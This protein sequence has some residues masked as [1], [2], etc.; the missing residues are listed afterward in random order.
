MSKPDWS[1]ISKLQRA[2]RIAAGLC[3][4]CARNP[5]T[6][7]S[8]LCDECANKQHVRQRKK[9][10]IDPSLPKIIP[11]LDHHKANAKCPV[12][13]CIV[14]VWPKKRKL[15]KHGHKIDKPPCPGSG[16]VPSVQPA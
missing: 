12:C 5:G 4:W 10:G 9:L 13:G 2:R 6:H 7:G 8:G 1:A 16:T 3:I 15:V 14:A 11:W